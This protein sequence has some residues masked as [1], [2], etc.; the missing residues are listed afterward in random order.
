VSLW[1]LT[2]CFWFAHLYYAKNNPGYLTGWPL[3]RTEAGVEIR[4]ASALLTK[5]VEEG[6][7]QTEQGE[8]GPFPVT[9]YLPTEKELA[10]D[11]PAAASDAIRRA[12]SD[13]GPLP[14]FSGWP[15]PFSRAWRTTPNGE[16]L[17]IYLD[18]IPEEL[19]QE[20]RRQLEGL[21]DA[22]GELIP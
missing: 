18:L 7:V 9:L 15:A 19:Y 16:E 12:V 5:L 8:C 3:I 10:L 14:H 17:D 13:P 6:L 21:K 1:L 4:G 2:R 11:L 20:R 22:L